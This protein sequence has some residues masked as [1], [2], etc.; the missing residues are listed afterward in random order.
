MENQLPIIAI[1]QGDPNGIGP[2]TILR[3]MQ[4]DRV[5]ELCT[6]VIYASRRVMDH[7]RRGLAI[8]SVRYRT[9]PAAADAAA[10]NFNLIDIAAPDDFAVTP[11]TASPGAG[12]LALAALEKATR[13]LADGA[14]DALVTAPID[15][16]SIQSPQF[17]FTGHTD[18]LESVLG[19]GHDH[20]LMILADER[21]RIALVTTHCPIA[22]VAASITREAIVEKLRSFSHSLTADFALTHPRIAVLALNPHAGDQGVI[23]TEERDIIIP[24]IEQARGEKVNCFGPYAADG[25]F[26]SDSYTRFDGVLAMYHDQ[27]LAPFKTIAMDSGVNY[28]AGLEKVRTSPDHGTAY[29]IAGTGQAS[30]ASLRAALF[31]AIDI[32]RNRRRHTV[33]TANPL[34]RQYFDKGKDNVV[35]DLTKD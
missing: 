14:V 23:G 22:Q 17:H 3:L 30:A 29:D 33:A 20:A 18:Y 21:L 2:E 25:F 6:P 12:A 28:T 31:A 1:S 4:D 5:L 13:D 8:D 16:H 34:R 26:G 24:A 27:G 10:G 15:K 19:H 32:W 11:G 9:V 7:Y 35:L